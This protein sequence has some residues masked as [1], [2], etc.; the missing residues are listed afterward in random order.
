[1]EAK[2][3]R[4]E[5]AQTLER[6]AACIA[7][8]RD[9][10]VLWL[11]VGLALGIGVYFAIPV[12]P[13]LWVG[14]VTV[15]AVLSLGAIVAVRVN[16]SRAY[17]IAVA[18]ITG[19]VA[20][21]FSVAQIRTAIVSAPTLA[22]KLGPVPI[23]GLVSGV[24]VLENG[25]R[26]TLDHPRIAG[27][28]P[29]QTPESVR[30][31]LRGNQAEV[32]PGD[33]VR[34]LA[35]LAPPPPPS[36]PGAFDFQRQSFF[37]GLGA[38]GYAIGT[39][40]IIAEAPA[41]EMRAWRFWIAR[42]R[43]DVATKVYE[44]VD[45]APAAVIVALM[46]GDRGAIP[47]PVIQAI[48]DSGIAH[49]LAI[50]GLHIGLV[51]GFLFVSLR[52]VL[53]LI[54]PLAL[55]FPVKKIAVVASL[56]AAG[57]YML[58]AGATIPSQ[59]AF[60]MIAIVLIA[61]LVDRRGIS[62]RLVAWAATVILLVRPESL[63]GASFQLSFAAVLGLVAVYEVLRDA[64]GVEREPRTWRRRVLLYVGGVAL[65]TLVAGVATA[66]F[67]IYHFNRFSDYW[68][69]TNMVA[70]PTT[71]LWIMPW[72]VVAFVLMPFGLEGLA[73]GPI[74]I[75]VDVVIWI[76]SAISQW[77]GAV[78]L[79]PPMPAWGLILV[80]AGGTWLCLWRGRWRLWGAGVILIGA[81]TTFLVQTPDVLIDGRAKLIA[82]KGDDGNLTVSSLR[83]ARFSRDVWLRY[84]GQ[85][86]R[87]MLWPRYGPSPDGRLNCDLLG[88]I[89][90]AD[91]AIIALV[92]RPEALLEDCQIA[93]VIVSTVPIAGACPTPHTIID[94][95]DLWRN[96]THALWV[97][98]GG[99]RVKSVNGSRG[100]RPWVLSPAS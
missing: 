45:G 6:V 100:T 74:A 49:L 81:S 87:A 19:I 5:F 22:K 79:L 72:A 20:V 62:M 15:V 18:M 9:R 63:L 27:L 94:R 85:E 96:G 53:A 86:E 67:V 10:W 64:R 11:P 26:I 39:V 44:Y 33:R 66:P 41:H 47:E 50:S 24:D 43:R 68:L 82:V 99:V 36:I 35:A 13:P 70:V 76:A 1:M 59:R 30:V 89:Y 93:D 37:N 25:R 57:G 75:G 95:F 3:R 51:A 48:R 31:R 54:P 83:A 56:V 42:L 46:T 34:L 97:E 38:V 65:T 58:L 12:E 14:P 40:E 69:V 77:P 2:I 55:R 61:V 80:A 52:C 98:G 91:G 16:Q 73:L 4:S 92:N 7:A 78:S 28:N 8:E 84:I 21:G 60:L 32:Q 29:S 71:A 17:V 23:V 90:H 88:C